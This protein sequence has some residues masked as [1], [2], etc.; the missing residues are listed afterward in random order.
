MTDTERA[1][2]IWAGE[3]AYDYCAPILAR[4]KEEAADCGIATT[5]DEIMEILSEVNKRIDKTR[6]RR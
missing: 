1:Q 3:A 6:N 4:I 5:D 2:L